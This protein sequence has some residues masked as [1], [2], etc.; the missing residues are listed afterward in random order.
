MDNTKLLKASEIGDLE[1]VKQLLSKKEIDV[2][3]KQI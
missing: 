1:T 2:N 3:C